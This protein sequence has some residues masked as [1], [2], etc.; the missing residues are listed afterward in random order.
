[1][2]RFENSFALTFSLVKKSVVLQDIW[3]QLNAPPLLISAWIS[4]S[5]IL[6]S[7]TF[8]GGSLTNTRTAGTVSTLIDE[9]W[10]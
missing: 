9:V 7:S 1:V 10:T 8:F 4:N 2:A 5:N 3:A 6:F